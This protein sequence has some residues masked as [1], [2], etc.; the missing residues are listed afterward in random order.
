MCASISD[1]NLL[2]QS[3]YDIQAIASHT[4]MILKGSVAHES[5]EPLCFGTI[6]F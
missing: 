6:L 2:M 4:L 5:S 1:I 3:L